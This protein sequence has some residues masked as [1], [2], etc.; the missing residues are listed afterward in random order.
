MLESFHT[1]QQKTSSKRDVVLATMANDAMD[2]TLDQKR[3]LSKMGTGKI[4]VA[5]RI[6]KP[7]F[8]GERRKDGLEN[9]TR[10]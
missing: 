8:L 4:I 10:T 5:V 7:K 3:S 2:R 9:L 1:D 6:R